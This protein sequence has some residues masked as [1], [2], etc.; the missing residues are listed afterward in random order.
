VKKIDANAVVRH[1][2]F[3]KSRPNAAGFSDSSPRS[4]SS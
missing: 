4:S 2:S 3:A 1:V